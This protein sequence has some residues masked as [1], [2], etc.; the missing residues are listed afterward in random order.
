MKSYLRFPL[1]KFQPSLFECFDTRFMV[2]PGDHADRPVRFHDSTLHFRTMFYPV[3][4]D[5]P[6]KLVGGDFLVIKIWLHNF[7]FMDEDRRSA[8]EQLFGIPKAI[9]DPREQVIDDDEG[10]S[11]YQS[12]HE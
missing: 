12:T 1:L 4:A 6:L 10:S 9:E 8:L 3:L 11:G 5:D 2:G 7:P